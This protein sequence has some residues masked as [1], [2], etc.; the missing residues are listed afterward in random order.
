METFE[1]KRWYKRNGFSDTLQYQNGSNHYAM[2][3]SYRVHVTKYRGPL[4]K[5]K[6][7]VVSHCE[8]TQPSSNHKKLL[9]TKF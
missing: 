2:T 6:R 8:A 4:L 5:L 9:K 3:W 7:P 1:R